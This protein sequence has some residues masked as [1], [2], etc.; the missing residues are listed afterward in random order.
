MCADVVGMVAKERERA[1]A[2]RLVVEKKLKQREAAE[3]LGVTPRQIKR[4]V[5]AWREGG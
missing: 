3:R 5:R 2:V 4:L 1:H